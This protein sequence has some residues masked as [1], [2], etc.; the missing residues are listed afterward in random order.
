MCATKI[1]GGTLLIAV[2]RVKSIRIDHEGGKMSWE[3]R[4]EN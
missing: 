1:G 2:G 4:G 3:A